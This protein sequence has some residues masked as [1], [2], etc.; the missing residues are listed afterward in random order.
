M[1]N[2]TWLY[3][4]FTHQKIIDKL[5]IIYYFLTMICELQKNIGS[6]YDLCTFQRK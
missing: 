5:I 4:L 2:N 1:V 6:F 3:I